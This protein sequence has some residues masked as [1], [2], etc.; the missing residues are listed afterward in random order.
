MNA[1]MGARPWLARTQDDFARMLLAR[2]GPGDRA[3]RAS[4]RGAR[5]LPRA[6]HAGPGSAE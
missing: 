4:R 2:G 1:R 3:R 6:R 5:D